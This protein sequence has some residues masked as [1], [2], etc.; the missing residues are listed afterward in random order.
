M[1][2]PFLARTGA[3]HTN[4][5]LGAA[6]GRAGSSIYRDQFSHDDASTA[7]ATHPYVS[8]FLFPS[9]TFVQLS[10]SSR[11]IAV[12]IAHYPRPILGDRARF[13]RDSDIW[14]RRANYFSSYMCVFTYALGLPVSICSFFFESL[15][16]QS[17]LLLA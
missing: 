3:R 5:L 1:L 17:R 10:P 2:S 11:H 4:R 14:L 9:H 16:Y 8:I 13:Y 7:L 12:C 15:D 6:E